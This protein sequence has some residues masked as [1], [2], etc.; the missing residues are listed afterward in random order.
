ML[1]AINPIPLPGM[2]VW[3]SVREDVPSP[4]G[5]R[6]L[7]IGWYPRKAALIEDKGREQWGE[8]CK[9]GTRKRGEG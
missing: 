7:G 8:I 1:P 9:D 3:K 2:S 5:T 4:A 6:C